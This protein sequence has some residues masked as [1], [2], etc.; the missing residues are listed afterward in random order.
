MSQK[1][2]EEAQHRQ[3]L[4]QIDE[5]NA[6]QRT[7]LESDLNKANNQINSLQLKLK[8]LEVTIH[9]TNSDY[10]TDRNSYEKQVQGLEN[11]ITTLQTELRNAKETSTR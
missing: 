3:R 11:H 7:K 1:L 8:S 5:E 10:T 4:E 2:K 6:K 9:K